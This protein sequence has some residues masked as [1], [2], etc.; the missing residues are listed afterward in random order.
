MNR[1]M[2]ERDIPGV[3]LLSGQQLSEA[4]AKSNAALCTIGAA[5]IQW[6]HSYVAKDKTFCIYLASGEEAIR[7]HAKLSGFPASRITEIT[8]IFDPTTARS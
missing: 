4:A 6:V 2:I 7:Q 3:D 1:Y 5:D 8:T